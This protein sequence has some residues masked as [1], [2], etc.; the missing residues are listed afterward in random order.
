VKW[1][2]SEKEAAAMCSST[3]FNMKELASARKL[4]KRK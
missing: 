4:L 3:E 2:L 1:G